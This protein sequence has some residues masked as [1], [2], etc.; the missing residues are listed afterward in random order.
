MVMSYATA[1][2]T[3]NGT[4]RQDGAGMYLNW[5]GRRSYRTR[6]PVPRVLEPVDSLSRNPADG[7]LIIEGDNLQV[8]I[9]LRAQYLGA[10]DVA[11]LDPPYNTGKKDFRY[12]D[13]RY[14]DPNADSDDA[15]YVTN[16]D[17]GRHTKWLNFMAPRLHL[18]H[19]L[20]ADHGVCFV[21]INDIELFRL[22]MLMDEIF[23]ESNRIGML[24]WKQA[25]DN[26]PTQIAVEHEYVLCYAK[27]KGLVAPAWSGGSEAREW[28]LET[29]RGLKPQFSDIP[30]LEKAYKAAIKK[31]VTEHNRQVRELGDSKL[32]DLGRAKRYTHVDERDAYAAEDNTHNPRAGGYVYD[33]IHPVT[34][35]VC[36]KAQA[37]V[38]T[39]EKAGS[40]PK[41]QSISRVKKPFVT[42][43]SA[44][45]RAGD[46]GYTRTSLQVR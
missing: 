15:V 24:I 30:E 17:G 16:E 29:Y 33:V 9:S 25:I 32:L 28:L 41:V 37:F 4:G 20:L 14:H 43:L 45:H 3:V 38:V 22:G 31:H 27:D 40:W 36:K 18:V 13:R 8:M 46:E 23:D 42:G 11:Y 6:M 2:P 19:D 5:E 34:G 1:G 26:N 35:Q 21:S 7:N 10:V 12:S 44:G 39:A